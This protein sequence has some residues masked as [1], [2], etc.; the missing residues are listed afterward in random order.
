MSMTTLQT[1]PGG[2][3]VAILRNYGALEETLVAK[4]V[5][6]VLLGTAYLHERDII[7]R[8]IKGANIL[9]K[10]NSPPKAS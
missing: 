4:F 3:I 6:Q 9:G 1:S 2:S 7:H 8:D 10:M 5:R